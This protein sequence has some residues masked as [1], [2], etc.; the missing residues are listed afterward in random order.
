MT[1]AWYLSCSSADVADRAALVGDPG[2]VDLFAAQLDDARIVAENRGLQVVTG[3]SQG[4]PVTVCAFGMGAP[5][6][7]IVLEELTKLGVATVVRVGTAMTLVAG[8]LG[9]L[10][11]ASGGVREEA[12]SATYLPPSFPAVPDPAL[13]FDL[14]VALESGRYR[15]R[16]GLVASL[17][18][19][20]T[21]MF[22]LRPEREERIAARL[23]GLREAGVVAVDMETSALL[24]VAQRLGVRAGSLCLASVDAES[25]AKL[26]GDEREEAEARLVEVALSALR[27][28]EG[29]FDRAVRAAAGIR[30]KTATQEV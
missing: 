3:A 17:D 4:V 26:E 2:R 22:A 5:I 23:R 25:R 6:A 1:E 24:T 27:R 11:V 10:V 15:Y 7:V 29:S 19:F 30:T 14:L 12:V 16:A 28:P 20:Y 21:E 8:S 13:L 18:G 9:E